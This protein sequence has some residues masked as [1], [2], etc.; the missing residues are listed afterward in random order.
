MESRN[1][2]LQGTL[3]TSGNGVGV[4]VGLGDYTVF[5]RIAKQ[6]TSERT[7]R[8]TLEAEILRLVLIIAGMAFIVALLIVSKP[9]IP[10]FV[11]TCPTDQIFKYCGPLG[12]V[13]ITPVL[14]WYLHCSSTAFQSRLRLSQVCRVKVLC[15]RSQSSHHTCPTHRGSSRLC[16]SLVDRY[17]RIFF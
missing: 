6:A 3:C 13:V 8:T 5:G 7:T 16:H 15:H 10:L 2:A 4:C 17:V 12:S 14:S 1:I 11:S 9:Q